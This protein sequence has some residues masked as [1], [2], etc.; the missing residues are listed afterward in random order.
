[1]QQADHHGQTEK[2]GVCV[3]QHP[4]HVVQ[5]LWRAHRSP[6]AL[7]LERE[8]YLVEDLPLPETRGPELNLESELLDSVVDVLD[9]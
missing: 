2:P 6:R 3:C 4:L 8:L 1:M 9:S 7:H 5:L